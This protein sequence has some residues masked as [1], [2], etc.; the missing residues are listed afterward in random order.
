ME[1]GVS[2]VAPPTQPVETPVKKARPAQKAS[3]QH[4]QAPAHA[5]IRAIETRFNRPTKIYGISP[6][7][8][9]S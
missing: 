8:A 5:R 3:A 1:E 7:S 4:R 6:R 2:I 9:A